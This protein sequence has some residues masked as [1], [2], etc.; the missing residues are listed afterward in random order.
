MSGV[1]ML[2]WWCT[3]LSIAFVWPQV[4][5]VYRQGTVEGIAPKGTLHGASASGFWMIYGLA[6]GDAAI[7]LANAAVVLAMVLI[8]VQQIRHHAMPARLLVLTGLGV[9]AASVVALAI[10]P[11]VLGWLAIAV[12]AT[13]VL[14]QTVHVLRTPVLT[15]VSVSMYVLLCLTALS[16]A[17]YGVLIGDPLVVVTNVLVLPCAALVVARTWLSQ[18]TELEPA[19]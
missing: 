6:R 4:V 2:G 3:V 12:G 13:S 1:E 15:G 16:W 17:V 14:P 8:A 5:R 18:R 10:S 11:A 9:L 7:A 19:I